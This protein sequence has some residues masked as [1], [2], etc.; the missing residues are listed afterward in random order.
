MFIHEEFIEPIEDG[1]IVLFA[2]W[3]VGLL[4]VGQNGYEVGA[5][6]GF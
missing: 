3:C 2:F 1:L 4:E 6:F 5:V